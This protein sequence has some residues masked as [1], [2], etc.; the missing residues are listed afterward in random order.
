MDNELNDRFNWNK[1]FFNIISVMILVVGG[2]YVMLK[3]RDVRSII[4]SYLIIFSSLTFLLIENGFLIKNGFYL[5]DNVRV[6][7][8]KDYFRRWKLRLKRYFGWTKKY[9]RR[10]W[11]YVCEFLLILALIITDNPRSYTCFVVFYLGQN[12]YRRWHANDI[13]KRI[14][15]LEEIVNN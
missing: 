3:M 11:S 2:V 5:K 8:N 14:K 12:I 6:E 4:I 1:L 10:N 7:L 13:K 9:L 15:D